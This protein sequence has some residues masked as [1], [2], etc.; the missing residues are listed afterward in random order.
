MKEGGWWSG[1]IFQT[2]ETASVRVQK[3]Q[4]FEERQVEQEK[5]G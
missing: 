5:E 4:R 3:R 2:E 1:R